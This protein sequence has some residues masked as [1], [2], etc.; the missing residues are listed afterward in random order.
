ML[1]LQ[2]KGEPNCRAFGWSA[3][4]RASVRAR[5]AI[6]PKNDPVYDHPV[7]STSDPQ[8]LA[9]AQ[10]RRVAAGRLVGDL[11]TTSIARTVRCGVIACPACDCSS[12]G[13]IDVGLVFLPPERLGQSTI[14]G[15]HS[16][17][18]AK[19]TAAVL[20]SMP[21]GL[22][23]RRAWV[24]PPAARLFHPDWKKSGGFG[25]R[26]TRAAGSPSSAGFCKFPTTFQQNA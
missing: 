15:V 23:V 25:A 5:C 24:Q 3:R 21:E 7:Q 26:L 16:L 10:C 14:P 17:H 19:C 11:V 8:E 6:T 22:S 2:A 20:R 13:R 4:C 18:T 1:A 9:R 12:A